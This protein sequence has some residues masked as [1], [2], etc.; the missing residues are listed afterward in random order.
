MERVTPRWDG[1]YVIF[2][3]KCTESILLYPFHV[4]GTYL[5]ETEMYPVYI[6]INIKNHQTP[7]LLALLLFFPRRLGGRGEKE[8][9]GK[10]GL[11]QTRL[12]PQLGAIWG[13]KAGNGL[14]SRKVGAV[15]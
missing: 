3:K 10:K 11:T 6:F 9:L 12:C 2:C 7:L 8:L 14:G 4:S 13:R 1:V 5:F 15:L